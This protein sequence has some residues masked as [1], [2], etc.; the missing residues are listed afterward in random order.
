MTIV[1]LSG[2]RFIELTDDHWDEVEGRLA[3]GARHREATANLVRRAV[4]AAMVPTTYQ[5]RTTG[6]VTLPGAFVGAV[7]GGV[8]PLEAGRFQIVVLGST[9][10]RSA[11]SRTAIT[12]VDSAACRVERAPRAHASPT[13]LASLQTGGSTVLTQH[14]RTVTV[15]IGHFVV[16]RTDTAYRLDHPG[17]TATSIH[18][19]RQEE[20]PLTRAQL[21]AVVARPV[22]VDGRV[23]RAWC[24]VVAGADTQDADL[25]G[26]ERVANELLF[27]LLSDVATGAGVQQSWSVLHAAMLASVQDFLDD[28]RLGV[29]FL[30]KRHGVSERRVHSTFAHLGTSPARVIRARRTERAVALLR[31]TSSSVPDVAILSGFGDVS[32]LRRARHEGVGTTPT[33]LRR[34]VRDATGRLVRRSGHH[35]DEPRPRGRGS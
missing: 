20:V 18:Q 14:G 4:H 23:A 5:T 25:A 8:S 15:P 17:R 33:A 13:L 34:E 28:P 32:T 7:F 11:S 22:R 27:A 12:R 31:G 2:R 19:V 29:P 21:D 30:A 26:T 24:R 3:L 35:H 1:T 6:L 16:Y 9:L 10:Q